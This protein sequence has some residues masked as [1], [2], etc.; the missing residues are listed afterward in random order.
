MR[1][2]LRLESEFDGIEYAVDFILRN[3]YIRFCYL[4]ACV[5]QDSVQQQQAFCAVIVRVIHI[6]AKCLAERMRREILYFQ[7]VL[8][9][10]HF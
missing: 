4:D 1:F 7:T 9:L 3:S 2:N 6:S 5:V 8:V 10:K